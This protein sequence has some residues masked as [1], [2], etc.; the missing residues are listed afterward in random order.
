[1]QING[2]LPLLYPGSTSRV[3][4]AVCVVFIFVYAFGYSLGFGP[5]A[6]LYGAEVRWPPWTYVFSISRADFSPARV[7]IFPTSVRARGLNLSASAGAVGSIIVAQ[8]WPVGVDRLGS[9]VYFF[10]M[11]VNLACIPVSPVPPQLP[12]CSF[13]QNL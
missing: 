12:P 2:A 4:N 7:Q 13:P 6:W 11:A 5:A 8:I 3:A 1:M 9:N 10:F